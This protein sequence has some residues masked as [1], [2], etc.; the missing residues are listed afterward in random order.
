M[1]EPTTVTVRILDKDYQVSCKQDEVQALRN[2]A[3]YVD[4][5]MR[6]IKESSS[7]F[8]LDRIAVMVALNIAND[9]LHETRKSEEVLTD[10][11]EN[12]IALNGKLDQAITRLKKP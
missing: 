7:I 3:H 8:G 11:Q 10:Q 5:K 9:F 6:E 1:T 2:S 4:G 12:L